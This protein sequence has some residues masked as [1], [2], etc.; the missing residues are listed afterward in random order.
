MIGSAFT[1]HLPNVAAKP[2]RLSEFLPASSHS[3]GASPTIPS[4]F[5]I[6]DCQE[7]KF[8]LSPPPDPPR[9]AHRGMWEYSVPSSLW[10]FWISF[11]LS[12]IEMLCECIKVF[13]FARVRSETVRSAELSLLTISTHLYI[14]ITLKNALFASVAKRDL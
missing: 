8:V 12:V 7:I 3:S 13:P 2:V 11:L 1:S 10:P 4:T 9:P 5:A 6:Q 14:I